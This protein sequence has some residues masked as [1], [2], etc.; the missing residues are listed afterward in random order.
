MWY[1]RRRN[2]RASIHRRY[3]SVKV[4]AS[5]IVFVLSVGNFCECFLGPYDWSPAI[6]A[7][8]DFYEVKKVIEGECVGLS[9][10]S[11]G[12][13]EDSIKSV[14]RRN[15]LHVNKYRLV[16]INNAQPSFGGRKFTYSFNVKAASKL[17]ERE[18][19]TMF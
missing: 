19:L 11:G 8:F 2:S 9:I 16:E 5:T 14:V 15:C 4:I 3:F 17:P 18:L 6:V 1:S 13:A 10:S 7:M 12:S